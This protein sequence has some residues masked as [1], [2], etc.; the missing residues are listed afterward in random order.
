M[1]PFP[2][3]ILSRVRIFT[4]TLAASA[5]FL[6]LPGISAAHTN[7]D[8]STPANNAKLQSAPNRVILRFKEAVTAHP[9][10]IEVFAPDGSRIESS[11]PHSSAIG[12]IEQKVKPAGD[13]EYAVSYRVVSEDGHTVTGII[14][15]TV[16][17]S[18]GS[19][20]AA[21]DEAKKESSESKYIEI[22]FGVGRGLVLLMLLGVAGGG[23]F[24][25]VISSDWKLRGLSWMLPVL[26]VSTAVTYVADTAQAN[27]TNL[28]D[29]LSST[30]LRHELSSPYGRTM[31][32]VAGLAVIATLL[33][34]MRRSGHTPSR[35]GRVLT[36]MLFA[37]LAASMSLSGHAI[38]SEHRAIRLPL[39]MLHMIAASL[40]IGGLLQL[41][42]RSA[43]AATFVD[44]VRRFSTI[45]F[46]CVVT[47]FITGVFATYIQVGLS[48]HDLT[49]TDYGRL[50]LA[51]IFLFVATMPMAALNKS[52]YVPALE[53]QPHDAPRLLRQYVYRELLILL[54]ILALTA[55]LIHTEPPVNLR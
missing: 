51:K 1:L 35:T 39:D 15:F 6:V 23:L 19:G 33:L 17:N 29:A 14:S 11:S 47:L 37:A 20:S 34:A 3:F 36:A 49:T 55:M 27:G 18:S 52:T 16:G 13:G 38:A 50:V 12:V 4:L 5:I 2:R 42:V 22:V 46:G 7:I 45:A 28:I 26:V 30:R 10:A 21:K 9:G 44:A 32:V 53:K 41:R 8:S 31:A 24:C 48:W 25:T 43:D 54:A 40:W